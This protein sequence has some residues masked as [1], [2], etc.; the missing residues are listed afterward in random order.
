MSHFKSPEEIREVMGGFFET[1][2]RIEPLVRELT[3]RAPLVLKLELWEPELKLEIDL[4]QMPLKLEFGS[5]AQGTVG[6]RGPADRFHELLLGAFPLAVGIN[7]K[8]LTVRGSTAR[9]MQA[10]PLFYLAPRLYPLYL[11]SVNRSD[12]IVTGVRAPLHLD[13]KTEGPMNWIIS[14]IAYLGGY[15][16]GFIKRRISPGLD[17]FAAL[18]SLGKGLARANPQPRANCPDHSTVN[19]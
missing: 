4:A 8:I 5:E 10:V 18:E 7:R 19:E 16:I 6:M 14:R 15:A 2:T 12:L 1:F 3:G 17:I 13:E 11:E 9:L